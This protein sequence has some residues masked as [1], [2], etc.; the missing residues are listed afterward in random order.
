MILVGGSPIE[1]LSLGKSGSIHRAYSAYS[2]Y[3]EH[4]AVG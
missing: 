4:I 2:K 3:F 1:H